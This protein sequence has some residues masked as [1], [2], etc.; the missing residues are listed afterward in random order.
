MDI[1][2]RKYRLIFILLSVI[3]LASLA[4][5]FFSKLEAEKIPTRGVFV[6]NTFCSEV[7]NE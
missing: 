4:W 5:V 2:V 6:L 3:I 1:V 7:N